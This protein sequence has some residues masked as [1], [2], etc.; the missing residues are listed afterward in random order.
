MTY[1]YVEID[2]DRK[3]IL[4]VKDLKTWEDY[5]LAGAYHEL[6]DATVTVGAGGGLEIVGKNSSFD[7]DEDRYEK[8]V[9]PVSSGFIVSY[10]GFPKLEL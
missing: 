8:H 10:A 7:V 5:D 3:R 1:A 9:F 2:W 6:I 4:L